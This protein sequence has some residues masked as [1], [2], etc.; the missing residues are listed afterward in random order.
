MLS[1][2]VKYNDDVISTSPNIYNPLKLKEII[3]YQ[4][5]SE[6]DPIH[7]VFCP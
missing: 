1:Y 3:N 7:P 4:H 2:V 6:Y 5:T